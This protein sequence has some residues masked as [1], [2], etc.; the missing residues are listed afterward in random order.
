MSRLTSLSLRNR[1]VVLLM[2][3]LIVVVG[4]Y[5]AKSLKQELIPSTDW[6]GATVISI[7]PGASPTTVEQEVTK[8]IEDA[9]KTVD[10]IKTF[11]STSS[12]NTSQV[13]IEWEWGEDFDKMMSDIRTA[14]DSA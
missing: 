6:P 1:T 2:A 10:N 9:V 4:L 12:S 13:Q 8:P 14:V 7:Y 5:S 3:V 11:N